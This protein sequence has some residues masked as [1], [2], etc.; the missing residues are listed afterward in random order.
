MSSLSADMYIKILG[1]DKQISKTPIVGAC[2]WM[3]AWYSS[4]AQAECLNYAG[5]ILFVRFNEVR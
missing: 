2:R 5:V 1:C 3:L 4:A